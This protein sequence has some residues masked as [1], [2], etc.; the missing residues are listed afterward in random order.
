[1]IFND[2]MPLMAAHMVV[3]AYVVGGF[4]V[5]S[6][7]AFAMLRGR[8][9]RYHRLGFIIAFS[10]A[11]AAIPIQM[12]VGD[13]LARWVY[14]N[15][16]VKFA[17]IELVPETAERRARDPARPPQLR[18]HGRRWHRD[19]RARVVAVGPERRHEH[20]DPGARLRS[21]P[22]SGRPTRQVNTVHLAW[23][24][25]VGL[26]TLLFLLS[27]WYWL[28]WIF[29]RDMPKSR[30]SC[31]IAS[32]AGVASVITMEAGWVVSEV[33]RQPWIVYDLMRVEDGATANTGVWITFLLVVVALHRRSASRRCSILRQMSRRFRERELDEH[34][35]PY[36]PSGPTRPTPAAARRSRCHEH[37]RCRSAARR[38]HGLRDLRRG[39]LRRRVLGPGGGWRHAWRTSPRA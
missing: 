18:R 28:C 22:T 21:R 26:G 31:W 29:R 24:V 5:A 4:L 19:S 17:A 16:P 9:D 38:H 7:Y 39:R 33:G 2:A 32:G 20:R 6:V 10:V 1:M 8:R 15:Q 37:G 36:G 27:A 11:A 34:D 23:D 13:S 3:A 14:E 12:A 25:M 35:V 30:R